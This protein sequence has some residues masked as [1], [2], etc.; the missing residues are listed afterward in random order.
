MGGDVMD[1]IAYAKAKK[2]LANT[3]KGKALH[4][5][6]LEGNNS[7]IIHI[8]GDSTGNDSN[9]WAYLLA[10][11]I[12]SAY[13]AHNVKYKLFSAS[14]GVYGAWTNIQTVGEER[15]LDNIPSAS[16]TY[17]FGL[18]PDEVVL[19]SADLDI[20]VKMAM[21]D[22]QAASASTWYFLDQIGDVSA[23]DWRW[24]LSIVNNIINLVWTT[25][26]NAANA[27]TKSLGIDVSPW[28]D[29]Q[30]YKFKATL[31]VDD[32][33][34]HYV[35]KGY[36]AP[37]DSETWT[38]T[39]TV[40][41]GVTTSVYRPSTETIKYYLGGRG[42]TSAV[43]N[44][45]CKFY[46]VIIRDGIDG[47]IA[48]PQPIDSWHRMTSGTPAGAFGGTPTIYVYN[49]SVAGDGV[50]EFKDTSF[51]SKAIPKSYGALLLYNLG[52]NDYMYDYGIG[53][54]TDLDILFGAINTRALNATKIM[55]TQ[56][57][58][59]SPE[60]ADQIINRAMRRKCLMGYAQLNKISIIDTYLEFLKDPRSIPSLLNADGLHPNPATGQILLR[61]TIC[62][63]LGL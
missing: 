17:N 5:G 36:T 9:E 47:Q 8:I 23:T 59:C 60:P 28:V 52:H 14:S 45:D 19:T 46:E 12:A 10:Q 42:S 3:S 13:P 21:D 16:T 34:G 56:S 15:Y 35:V 30:A 49:G 63:Q 55:I 40:M 53:Y 26:G 43:G 4:G 22:W 25:D 6:L 39:N 50:N 7:Q 51:L 62:S 33:A 32:G 2:S 11:K 29:G 31:D 54:K 41:G 58:W 27:I 44:K 37:V 20:T 57:P 61:D 18:N 38:L 1:M 24:G 48:N